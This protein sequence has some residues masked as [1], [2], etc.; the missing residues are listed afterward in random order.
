MKEIEIMQVVFDAEIATHE[1]PAFRGAIIEKV[2]L[3]HD[4]FHNHDNSAQR[5]RDYYYR[6]PL[7]QY[8]QNRSR[9]E[10]V[11]LQGAIPKA[12][13]LFAQSDWSLRFAGRAQPMRIADLRIGRHPFGVDEQWHTYTLR[14]WQALNEDNFRRY[15]ATEAL[16]ERIA[17]LERILSGHIISLAKG[18]EHRLEGRFEVSIADLLGSRMQSYEGIKARTFDLRFRSNVLLPPHI[19]LGKG[20][21]LGFG[22][23]MRM[24]GEEGNLNPKFSQAE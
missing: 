4:I 7:V 16:S 15:S 8:R 24:K 12:Q 23:V 18:M 13:Y 6:Y 5:S 19:A 21:S 17:M 3:E 1:T 22:T 10:L 20:V 14:R 2:G 11:F 9:P